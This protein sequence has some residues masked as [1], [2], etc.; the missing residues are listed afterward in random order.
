MKI[1]TPQ[2]TALTARLPKCPTGIQG[3]DEITGGGLP[4]NVERVLPENADAHI[5][6]A[7]WR[8]P[9]IFE[10]LQRTGPWFAMVSLEAPHPPYGAPSAGV[11]PR[12]V[13]ERVLPANVPRGTP[14]AERA[15][16]EAAVPGA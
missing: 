3:L 13:E 10:W 8:R 9:A 1:N 12:P 11:R 14:A 7:A 4:G 16:L 6:P 5:N 15:R 2:S